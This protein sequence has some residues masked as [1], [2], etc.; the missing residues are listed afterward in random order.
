MIRPVVVRRAFTGLMGLAFA[1]SVAGIFLTGPVLVRSRRADLGVHASAQRLRRDVATLCLQFGPRDAAHPE[2]LDRAAAWIAEQF[3]QAGLAVEIQDYRVGERTFHNVVGLRRGVRGAGAAV[4]FGAHY[5][6]LEGSAGADDNASGVAVLLDLARTLPGIALAR[7]V[8]LVAFGTGEGSRHF[9]RSYLA[10]G[11]GVHLMLSLDRVGD[12]S[13]DP[14][15]PLWRRLALRVLYPGAR[16]F[17]ILLGDV[18]AGPA[19]ER[20][21]RG[22]R[23]GGAGPVVSL[24][25]PAWLASVDRSDH[26]PFRELGFPAVQLT[27]A[28]FAR[29]FTRQTA[30]TP[31][32]LDY[33]RMVDL[34]AALHGVLHEADAAPR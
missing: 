7:D 11:R 21:K 24:R 29:G 25:A 32:R 1:V 28:T 17:S 34:V 18:R 33:E 22:L 5:D 6:A 23:L 31:D 20:A 4:I 10:G 14:D 12:Y 19:I 8:Y 26:V 16:N 9:A 15:P 13:S 27:D 30:D 3:G 2:N